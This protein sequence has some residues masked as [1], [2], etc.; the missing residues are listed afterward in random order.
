MAK[1]TLTKK[2]IESRRKKWK[3]DAK[4][5][6][7]EKLDREKRFEAAFAKARKSGAKTFKFEGRLHP[8]L[9]GTF[10]TLTAEEELAEKKATRKERERA[11]DAPLLNASSR[12]KREFYDKILKERQQERDA[13]PVGFGGLDYDNYIVQ[14]R[15]A[16]RKLSKGATYLADALIAARK[17]RGE[18]KAVGGLVKKAKGGAVKKKRSAKKAKGG[19]VTKW[20]S[21][22]G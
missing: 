18:G 12:L 7:E 4:K 16:G 5:R 6:A 10:H 14:E 11:E 2:Q 20:E 21:K 1:K 3:A 9:E 8:S 17:A 22:W 19:M 15:E 13:D